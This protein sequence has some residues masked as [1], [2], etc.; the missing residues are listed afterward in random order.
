MLFSCCS[1]QSSTSLRYQTPKT[2][3]YAS[4]PGQGVV[5]NVIARDLITGTISAYVPMVTY[6]CDFYAKIDGCDSLGKPTIYGSVLDVMRN[7]I[8]REFIMTL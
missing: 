7:T 3:S 4:T 8:Q 5:Y 1:I 6:S 2:A